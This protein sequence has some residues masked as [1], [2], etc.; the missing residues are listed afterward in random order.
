MVA[1]MRLDAAVV[2]G[3]GSEN[4]DR[5]GF[6]ELDP[7]EFPDLAGADHHGM[8]QMPPDVGDEVESVTA[9]QNAAGSGEIPAQPH[10][11]HPRPDEK[12]AERG[13][14]GEAGSEQIEPLRR[15]ARPRVVVAGEGFRDGG[16]RG[17]AE[18]DH[19]AELHHGE[20]DEHAVERDRVR[21]A[22]AADQPAAE[23]VF[24]EAGDEAAGGKG[25]AVGE[26]MPRRRGA[27]EFQRR[28]HQ[29]MLFP[30]RGGV[31]DFR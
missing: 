4:S 17:R 5:G 14:H 9:E 18:H 28:H 3:D 11:Q 26:Q 8:V 7:H 24:D 12:Q 20:G 1:S 13:T 10:R 21:A 16:P 22:G 27:G 15:L 2:E 31:A 19:E 23:V 30:Q 6:D 29:R 25:D